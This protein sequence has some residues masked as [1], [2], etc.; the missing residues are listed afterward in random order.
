M[1]WPKRAEIFNRPH[2]GIADAVID[3]GTRTESDRL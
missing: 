2:V 3:S 1:R